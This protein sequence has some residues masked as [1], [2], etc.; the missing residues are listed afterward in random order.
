MRIAMSSRDRNPR[1]SFGGKNIN[2]GPEQLVGPAR[3]VI[4]G[5][6]AGIVGV[7]RIVLSSDLLARGI[8]VNPSDATGSRLIFNQFN[9]V[10][11]GFA[12]ADQHE[13]TVLVCGVEIGDLRYRSKQAAADRLD[14]R[15]SIAELAA[16]QR[17]AEDAD[18]ARRWGEV[19]RYFNPDPLLER[20][21][22][23]VRKSEHAVAVRR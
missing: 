23:V 11:A 6:C 17:I 22:Q 5:A 10:A 13:V 2:A 21:K 8:A 3:A 18:S 14:Q 7:C 15:Q 9:I 20:R 1:S 19:A 4:P 12:A 16:M